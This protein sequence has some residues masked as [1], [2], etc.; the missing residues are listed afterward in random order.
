MWVLF[1]ISHESEVIV[2]LSIAFIIQFY[3]YYISNNYKDVCLIPKDDSISG[4]FQ[5]QQV[6]FPHDSVEMK[7]V[8]TEIWVIQQNLHFLIWIRNHLLR[9]PSQRQ[10]VNQRNPP[11]CSPKGGGVWGELPLCDCSGAGWSCQPAVFKCQLGS[12]DQFAFQWHHLPSNPC[13]SFR[14]IHS[15]GPPLHKPAA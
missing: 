7:C 6:I 2:L 9:H 14:C 5:H 10:L 4:C 8:P 11:P 12:L 1:N 3:M 15:P 13:L